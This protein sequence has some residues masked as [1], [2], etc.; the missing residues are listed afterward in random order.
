[1][2]KEYLELG[3]IVGTH[4]VKGELRVDPWCDSPDF[5]KP[6]KTL[7]FDN[8]G[9]KAVEI[10]STRPHGKMVLLCLEGIDSIELAAALRGRVLFMRRSDAA[11]EKGRYFISELIG[12]KVID[13][14]NDKIEYGTISQV[15]ATGAN[16]VWHIVGKNNKEYLLPAIPMVIIDADVEK[17]TVKIRPL[18]GIFDDED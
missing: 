10:K 13:A 5:F 3:R 17:E 1:M 4:G 15:S 7:Y 18:K 12:C 16:D 2:I 11:L 14:D 8:R 9:Q 6:L